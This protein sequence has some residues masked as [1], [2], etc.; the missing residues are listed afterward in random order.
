M[1]VYGEKP[2]CEI[3]KYFRNNCWY[4]RPLWSYVYVQVPEISAEDHENGHYNS[5]YLISDAQAKAIAQRLNELLATGEVAEY[6]EKYTANME[7]LPD[8]PCKICAGTGIRPNGRID[9]G[10]EWFKHTHGCNGCSGKGKVRPHETWYPFDVENVREF[11]A[12]AEH[13]GGFRIS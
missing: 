6:E 5:G 2:N 13:S 1:D 9:F 12:F 7:S 11:A 8:E 3:G 10:E 4:W